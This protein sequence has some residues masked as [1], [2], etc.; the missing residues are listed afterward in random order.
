VSVKVN[1]KGGMP[2]IIDQHIEEDQQKPKS[3][4]TL[5]G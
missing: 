2:V 1:V 5:F 4:F 3:G